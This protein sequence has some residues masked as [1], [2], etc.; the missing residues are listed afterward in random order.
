[1]YLTPFFRAK[2]SG[3]EDNPNDYKLD[4]HKDL[5][6]S[7]PSST[8]AQTLFFDQQIPE[9]SS[10]DLDK[11]SEINDNNISD[12]GEVTL[13]IKPHNGTLD[14]GLIQ[15]SRMSLGPLLLDA[16]DP[17]TSKQMLSD[18]MTTNTFK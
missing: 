7:S 3:G 16:S 9:T 10:S 17:M 12:I 1:M 8:A 6:V 5:V 18:M 14:E 15:D 4:I 11:S 13:R 2:H